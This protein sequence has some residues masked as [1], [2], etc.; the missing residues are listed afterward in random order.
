MTAQPEYSS[1][2]YTFVGDLRPGDEVRTYGKVTRVELGTLTNTVFFE[3]TTP[4]ATKC[5]T[6]HSFHS[7]EVLKRSQS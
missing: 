5:R 3:P 2:E 7:V 4:S 1:W 6:W